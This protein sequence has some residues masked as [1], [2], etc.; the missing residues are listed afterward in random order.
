MDCRKCHSK[1]DIYD[2]KV[3]V[4]AHHENMLDIIITCPKCGLKL[5][6]FVDTAAMQQIATGCC[7]TCGAADFEGELR[8]CP[9]CGDVKCSKCDMGDDVECASCASQDE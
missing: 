4:A 5:N 9:H 7:T 3:E 1:M 2:V 6:E 8:E